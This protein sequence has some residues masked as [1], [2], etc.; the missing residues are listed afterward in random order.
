MFVR[1][2]VGPLKALKLAICDSVP[3]IMIIA[4]ANG[5]G[6]STLLQLLRNNRQQAEP[7]TDIIYMAPHRSWRKGQ[8]SLAASLTYSMSYGEIL[9]LDTVPAWQT[10]VP[11]GYS[12][13][14]TERKP[15][16]TDEAQSLIKL[17]LVKI[18]QRR[19]TQLATS[20]DEQGRQIGP[21][22]IPDIYEPLRQLTRY[23]LPHL[24]FSKI[25]TTNPQDARCLFERVDVDQ[26]EIIDIDD[27]SSGEKSIIAL[28][29]P[30]LESTIT[31][32]IS[33]SQPSAQIAS[34]ALI[35]EP[36]LHLHP[37]LQGILLEYIRNTSITQN[38]QFI[39]ATQSATLLDAASDDELF[40]L[41]PASSTVGHN[42]LI[43]VADNF[44]RLEAI[45]ELTGSTYALTRFR[46]VVF[47]EGPA[48]N[49]VRGASD[50][51]L[52]EILLPESDSWTIVPSAG[53][54]NAQRSASALR[55]AMNAQMKG[56]PV[57]GLV[58]ADYVKESPDGLYGGQSA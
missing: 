35:D 18:E 14:N 47:I 52:L 16:T 22:T 19:Q 7:G 56:V 34:T 8:L 30:Y 45:R 2:R 38:I 3:R 41:A 40:T 31:K 36:E 39:I 46:P 10:F 17:S 37:A 32:M 50:Q 42:Q 27:L 6:K 15:D 49:E 25:D 53:R 57:F 12:Q 48:T 9:K 11:P 29:L 51:R 24:R 55:E 23:L 44:D 28:F 13:F 33:P 20:F 58:D 54:G 26:N 1:F 43:R 4:G 21:G 5:A